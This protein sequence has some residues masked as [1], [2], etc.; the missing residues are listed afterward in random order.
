MSFKIEDVPKEVLHVWG[1]QIACELSKVGVGSKLWN[2]CQD[3]INKYPEW[4]PPDPK[5]ELPDLTQT[6]S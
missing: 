6:T 4:F 3:V 2:E 1:I 5:T